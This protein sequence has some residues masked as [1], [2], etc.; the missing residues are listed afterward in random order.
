MREV[1]ILREAGESREGSFAAR[2]YKCEVTN[3]RHAFELS[4]LVT[5]RVEGPS[6]EFALQPIIA[7][8]PGEEYRVN[9]TR[10]QESK[11]LG[12]VLGAER[13]DRQRVVRA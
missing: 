6:I 4:L 10:G 7:Y 12:L 11:N 3:Q 13:L 5:V 2:F 9:R 1:T 8:E